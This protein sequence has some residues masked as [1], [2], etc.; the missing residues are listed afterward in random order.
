MNTDA[1]W[2]IPVMALTR[3]RVMRSCGNEA[4]ALSWVIT[5]WLSWAR[6]SARSMVIC[7]VGNRLYSS[8]NISHKKKGLIRSR[9]HL[10]TLWILDVPAE[11]LYI[12]QLLLRWFRELSINHIIGISTARSTIGTRRARS[13]TRTT[14]IRTTC[15]LLLI[16]VSTNCVK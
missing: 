1:A 7:L 10:S 3:P 13:S 12:S 2:L 6:S 11:R 4:I 14:S 8:I 15:T 16:Q 9:R 5:D